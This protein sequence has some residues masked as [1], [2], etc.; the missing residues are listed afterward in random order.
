MRCPSCNKF[1]ALEMQEPEV[2]DVTLTADN[3]D[4]DSATV[5]YD[6]RIVRNSE[7]CGDE[8]KEATFSDSVDVPGGIVAKMKEV[9][10]ENKD[11]EFDVTYG[12]ADTIEEGGG[13]YAKSY[14]GF[15]LTV[16]VEHNGKPL[17]EF[18]ITDKIAASYMDEMV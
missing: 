18:D 15:T 11:A 1:A 3:E 8:M 13:R 9:V 12:S 5:E 7:C 17:G 6:V 16:T 2:N 4:L 10:A 14:Y